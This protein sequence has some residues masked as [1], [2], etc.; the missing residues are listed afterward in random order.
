MERMKSVHGAVLLITLF[1]LIGCRHAVD[2]QAMTEQ[3]TAFTNAT[4][5]SSSEAEPLPGMTL[6]MEGDAIAWV[7]P[8]TEADLD[9]VRSIDVT[10][11]MIIPGLVDAHAHLSGLGQ[12]LENVDLVGTTSYEEVVR[13][14]QEMAATLPAGEWIRG[15]GWD[16]NDWDEQVFPT[17][18]SLDRA[19]PDHP[20]AAA[21][22]D[23]H[24]LLANTRALE[25]AGIDDSTPDPEGGTILRDRG[26]RATGVFVDNAMGLIERVIPQGTREDHKRQ[27][28]RAVQTAAAA[29][30][31]G[32]HDAGVSQETVDILLELA[33]EGRLPIRV[34]GM[35]SDDDALL[36]RWYERGPLIGGGGDRVTVRSIKLYADGALGS[37][38]AALHEPYTDAPDQTGLLVSPPD[39][40]ASVATA[41]RAHGFQVGTHAIGDRGSSIVIDAYEDAGAEPDDRFRIE[42][43]QVV[44][45]ED[46]DRV[47]AMGVIASMQ[48]T[49]ATSDMPWAEQR[50]GPERI[51]G[52]YA[53]RSVLETGIPLAFGSDFPVEEVSPFLGLHAAATRQDLAG[54]PPGGWTPREKVSVR[55]AIH[56]FTEGAA[57]AEF[58]ED[59]RGRLEPGMQADFVVLDRNLLEIAPR[60][61]P[62]TR[63]IFTVTGGEIVY[64]NPGR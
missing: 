10:G 60:D 18:E 47:R 56:G 6:I 49:H 28:E 5:L 22:I 37:R 27:L 15:R 14:L 9:G 45:L 35:L 40:I 20:V 51:K 38:G 16:Q 23:G 30:L 53:W 44:R 7:G 33:A 25:L 61:I 64:E 50:L 48:P 59:R 57:Y 36:A 43:L 17:R 26:G 8:T 34:Y 46:L 4:I 12:A 13:R 39:H 29:G 32:V 21:R 63:V 41:A 54:H 1:A 24:A 55:E 52:G 2:Q 31:T 3:R 62:R 42:H 58:A 11:A 19:I